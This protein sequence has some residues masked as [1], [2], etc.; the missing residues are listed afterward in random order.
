MCHAFHTLLNKLTPALL[1]KQNKCMPRAIHTGFNLTECVQQ[2]Q[3][4][5]S[6]LQG[7]GLDVPDIKYSPTRSSDGSNAALIVVTYITN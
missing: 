7:C 3:E 4:V 1:T 2:V 5:E 6:A